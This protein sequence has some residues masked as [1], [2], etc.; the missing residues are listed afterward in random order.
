MSGALLIKCLEKEVTALC[1]Y[2]L[3]RNIPPCFVALVPQEEELDDQKIQVTPAGFQ[4][5]FLCYADN[6]G[7]VPFTK[8]VMATP[9]QVD[10]VKAIVQKLRFKYRSDS[11]ENSVL[12]QHSRNLEALAFDLME[13]EQAVDLTLPEVEAMNKKLGSPLVDKFKELLYPPDYNHEGKVSNIKHNN[14]GFRSKRP[15]VEYSEEKL[16]NHI[17]NGTLGKFTVPMLKEKQE[18]LEA[19]TNHFQN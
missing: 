11:F 18:P 13:P 17:S 4:L 1:R 14:E 2:T 19:L 8:K 6:K 7:K 3:C 15:K 10:K 9:E 12:Q 5:V 16:K